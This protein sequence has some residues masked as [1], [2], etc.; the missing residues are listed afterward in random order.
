MT[1][2]LIQDDKQGVVKLL[3]SLGLNPGDFRIVSH[4]TEG[5]CEVFGEESLVKQLRVVLPEH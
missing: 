3:G 4:E 2:V 1:S 5:N